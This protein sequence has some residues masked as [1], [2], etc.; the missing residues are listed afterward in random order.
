M[1]DVQAIKGLLANCTDEQRREVFEYLRG[2]FQIHPLEST[3]HTKAEIILGAIQRAGDLTRRMFRGVL[4][5]AAFDFEIAEK[6]AGWQLLPITGDPPYDAH[7]REM[8]G[9]GEVKV[10]VKL[11]R[12]EA[13]RPMTGAD[14]PKKLAFADTMFVVETDKS[15]KGTR[16]GQS[17]RTYRF[18]DFDLLAVSLYPSTQRWDKFRYT[19]GNWL[20]PNP[21]D[22]A[23]I[24]NYQPVPQAPNADWTDDFLT[25]VSWLRAGTQRTIR[26]T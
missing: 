23:L 5:G 7:L 22:K 4:A 18:G 26:A 10:Q 16:K 9:A 17:T 8:S 15:R 21:K 24:L 20:I 2:Q 25:A 12:S 1:S 19:V 3:L 6:L 11:Q 13:G 14:A